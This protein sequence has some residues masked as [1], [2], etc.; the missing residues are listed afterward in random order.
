[1]RGKQELNNFKSQKMKSIFKKFM[2]VVLFLCI[3]LP[4]FAPPGPPP[5]GDGGGEVVG[6][7]AV[8]LDGGTIILLITGASILFAGSKRK[9]SNE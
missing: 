6:G 3:S 8:P 7:A 5:G 9:F 2:P 4:M 1:M